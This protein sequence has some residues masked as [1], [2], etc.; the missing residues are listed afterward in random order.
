[1]TAA[2]GLALPVGSPPWRRLAWV[3]WR[4]H[5]TAL[6]VFVALIGLVAIFMAV[7]GFVLHPAGPTVFNAGP[8]SQWRLFNAADTLLKV[9]L[10]LT[11]ALVGLFFGAPLIAR[12]IETGADR[13]TWAQGAGRTRWFVA[14]A[15]QTVLLLTVIAI[16]L[17]L[18]YRWWTGPLLGPRS[19]W[20]PDLFDLQPLAFTGWIVLGFTLGVFFGA[21]IRRTVAAMAATVAGYL[22]LMYVVAADWR[23]NY[24]SPLREAA[25]QPQFSPGG[26]YGYSLSFGRQPGSGPGPDVLNSALGWPDGRLL[27]FSQYHHTPAWFRLHHIQ[28]WVTYQPGS[29]FML[30]QYIEFGW[31]IVLSAILI[32]AA[33]VLIR[34]RAA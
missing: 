27:R 11:P 23:L 22:A 10:P 3:A 13:F 20:R 2:T 16:G 18:E 14:S 9:V 12:E 4:Q 7:T 17:G 33:L 19:D 34:R 29:R 24:L 31:L 8:N 30:F 21:V 5:R 15:V 26:G 6:T 1:M 28:V 25:A 32:A